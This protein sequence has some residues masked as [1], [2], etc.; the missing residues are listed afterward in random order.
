MTCNQ[1]GA[2]L[3]DNAR[4]CLQCGAPVPVQGIPGQP[5]KELDFLQPALAGGMLL[6]LLSSIPIVSV[7]CCAWVLGGGALTTYLLKRQRPGNLSYGDGAFGG[8]MAGLVGA[9][10][11]TLVSI[12]V[13]LMNANGLAEMRDQIMAQNADAPEGLRNFLDMILSPEIHLGGL[14][15]WFFMCAVAFGLL[16]M[17]GGIVAVA[18]VNRKPD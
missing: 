17:I 4:F 3:P 5:Q 8:V 2:S 11:A 9:V 1:C 16:A 13:R 15:V 7:L 18:V 6:G 10:V 14:L 12:P